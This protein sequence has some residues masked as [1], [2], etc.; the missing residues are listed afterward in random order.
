MTNFKFKSLKNKKIRDELVVL[1]D[2]TA[3][4]ITFLQRTFHFVSLLSTSIEERR[5]WIG[6][7]DR[8]KFRCSYKKNIEQKGL[9][10][11]MENLFGLKNL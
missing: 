3:F 6:G 10:Y 11:K 1:H 8:A 2:T 7:S 5:A 9:I 4:N